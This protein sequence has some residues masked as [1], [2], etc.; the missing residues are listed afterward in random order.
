ML[1][2]VAVAANREMPSG[3]HEFEFSAARR[4]E[5]GDCLL[6]SVAVGIVFELPKDPLVPVGVV[7]AQED[8]A[9]EVLLVFGE[10]A[11]ADVHFGDVGDVPVVRDVRSQK[12]ASVAVIPGEADFLFLGGRKQIVELLH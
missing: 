7:E 12:A 4:P 10:K 8:F 3:H 1:G 6:L 5:D 2:A 11:A 9:N